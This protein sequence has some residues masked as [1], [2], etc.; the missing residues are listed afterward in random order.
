MLNNEDALIEALNTAFQNMLDHFAH[1][2]HQQLGNTP[3]F[4]RNPLKQIH[5]D[6]RPKICKPLVNRLLQ[7]G[8]KKK[9]GDDRIFK[10]LVIGFI[11]YMLAPTDRLAFCINDPDMVESFRRHPSVAEIAAEEMPNNEGANAGW[12]D[13]TNWS[14]ESYLNKATPE[15]A[16]D[17][18]KFCIFFSDV[19][20]FHRV[21]MPEIEINS[22][23]TTFPG[24]YQSVLDMYRAFP[25]QNNPSVLR[26]GLRKLEEWLRDTQYNGQGV[27]Q[28]QFA[29][30]LQDLAKFMKGEKPAITDFFRNFFSF[31][32]PVNM[33]EIYDQTIGQAIAEAKTKGLITTD[34]DVPVENQDLNGVLTD[35]SQP[36]SPAWGA[37]QDRFN[38][39]QGSSASNPLSASASRFLKH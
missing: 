19:C 39:N 21:L 37:S 15:H 14:N 11:L 22:S 18:L 10:G 35:A 30:A 8:E 25:Y 3:F 9:D 34:S 24:I 5:P 20:D 38:S 29:Q 13:R 32:P 36:A 7:G 6:Q 1:F 26:I 27:T 16:D 17:Q 2:G 33:Q 28:A 23:Q 31:V 4:L 12:S